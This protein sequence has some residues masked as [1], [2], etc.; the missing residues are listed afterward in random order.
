MNTLRDLGFQVE[1]FDG[2]TVLEKP[3]NHF[4]DNDTDSYDRPSTCTSAH[5]RT[6]MLPFLDAGWVGPGGS[7]ST[8]TNYDSTITNLNDGKTHTVCWTHSVE[9]VLK[10]YVDGVLNNSWTGVNYNSRA[11]LNIIG[12]GYKDTDCYSGSLAEAICYNGVLT[13][14]N[15]RDLHSRAT[16]KWF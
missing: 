8:F 5:L 9:G 14:Q 12:G 1:T 4:D 3:G 11:L 13:D 15:V 6:F 2:D 7:V 10:V 16:Q